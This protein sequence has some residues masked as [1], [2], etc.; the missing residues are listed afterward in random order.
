MK[1]MTRSRGRGFIM[2]LVAAVL[3]G[4]SGTVAQHLFHGAGV[5]EGWLVTVRL[6][7]SGFLLLL[8][9]FFRSGSDAVWSLWRSPRDRRQ[10]LLLGVCGMLAVQYT[11]FASIAAGN[12]ATATLLQYLGP[13]LLTS[14]LAIRLRKMPESREWAAVGSALAGTF[15]LVTGGDPSTLSIS[16]PALIWGLGSAVA[17]AFYT[18]YP[19]GLLQRWESGTVVGWAMLI[20]GF[21]L[22]L[23]YPPWAVR[24]EHWGWETWGW[25]AVVVLFGTLLP[26]FLYL[27][28]LR[29]LRP[30]E[31]GLLSCAEPLSAAIAAVWWLGV[32]FGFPEWTGAALIIGTVILLSLKKEKQTQEKVKQLDVI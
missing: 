16:L 24:T 1:T 14:W 22:S 5:G 6:F 27:D 2:V 17:L 8:W 29:F 3:W 28:S 12:A 15:L 9:M 13:A 32:P 25:I 11:Y 23:L 31:T 18:L 7:I 21:A 20:G 4:L 26:F 30:S 10:V 19:A